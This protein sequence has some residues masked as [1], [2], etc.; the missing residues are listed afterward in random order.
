MPV[1]RYVDVTFSG[2]HKYSTA[3]STGV[4]VTSL[5]GTYSPYSAMQN[6]TC[7]S[8]FYSDVCGSEFY[9]K[10][11]SILQI[12]VEMVVSWMSDM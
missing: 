11:N 7:G 6:D 9:P 5:E 8:E 1:G 4:P 2:T 3:I 10:A 12:I